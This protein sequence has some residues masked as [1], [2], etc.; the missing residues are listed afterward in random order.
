MPR[1]RRIQ[2]ADAAFQLTASLLTNRKQRQRQRRFVVEGVRAIN[3]ALARGWPIESL[4]YPEG[5][6]L[7]S[8][9]TK[10]LGSDVGSVHYELAPGLFAELS[11]KDEPSELLAVAEIPPD[12][13]SRIPVRDDWLVVVFDRPVSP[14]NLGSV[15][16]SAD[17]L[18]AD[19]VVVTGHAADVYDPQCVRASVGSLF[20]LPVVRSGSTGDVREWLARVRRRLPELVVL[21]TSA[22]A[23]TPIDRFDLTGPAVL[24]VGNETRGMSSAWQELADEIALIPMGGAA[25]S[26]NAAA[27]A[28]VLLYEADRQRRTR[29]PSGHGA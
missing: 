5:R 24:V 28:A 9:A 2:S 27:A 23:Q 20:A 21:G 12:D 8:W 16:R 13:V 29:D 4:W 6:A 15:I 22:Q 7:S 14:G 10:L 25:S 17:A 3:G 18:N 19:G 11:G 26:L 1:V